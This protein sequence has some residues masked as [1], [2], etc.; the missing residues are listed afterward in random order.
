MT[1]VKVCGITRP[2]D[3][4]LAVELGAWALGFILW[5]GSKRAADPAVAA[6]IAAALRRRVQLVGVFVN[7]AL[8]E[9]ARAAEDLQLSHV[10]LHGDE[11]PAFCAE[12]GRRTGAKIIKA[13]EKDG[14]LPAYLLGRAMGI[15]QRRYDG[16][17]R[18]V[19]LPMDGILS[20][21][22]RKKVRAKFGG[23]LKALVAGGAAAVV[24]ARLMGTEW[25]TWL[26]LGV[27]SAALSHAVRA[28]LGPLPAMAQPR[29][30]L[31]AALTSVLV[32]GVAPYLVALVLVPRA[33]L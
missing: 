27:A 1:R 19:D 32:V 11:G 9:V 7:P 12:V 33:L 5:D 30:R 24:V 22:L 29:P 18:V 8:D 10:Q 15:E 26:L 31:V 13:I 28:V 6:R 25:T 23:R 21:T 4:E 3:A 14:G 20:L 2:E 17:E 16:R